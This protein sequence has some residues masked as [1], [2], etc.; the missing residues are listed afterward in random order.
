MGKRKKEERDG[1]RMRGRE[2]LER[3]EKRDKRWKGE[4]RN[5]KSGKEW[6]TEVDAYID[7]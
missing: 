4:G 2:I 6:K 7:I 1:R 3:V 5:R